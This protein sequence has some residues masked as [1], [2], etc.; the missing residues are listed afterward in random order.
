MYNRYTTG[1]TYQTKRKLAKQ[2][3]QRFKI[4]QNKDLSKI[5]DVHFLK[6][7][8]FISFPFWFGAKPKNECKVLNFTSMEDRERPELSSL[9][10]FAL[11]QLSS[12]R[13]Y[14]KSRHQI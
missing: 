5:V 7:I 3:M 14:H 1:R 12:T 10:T 13:K 11:C 9:Q 8:L 4:F 6:S 2:S